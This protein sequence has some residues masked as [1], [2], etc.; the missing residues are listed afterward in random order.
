MSSYNDFFT[1][2]ASVAGALTGLLFVALSLAPERLRHVSGHLEHQA[3]AGTAFTALIDALFLSLAGLIPPGGTS[4]SLLIL[5]LLG[6]SSS[7]GL[8]WR[9]W[10]ARKEEKLSARWPF[11]LGVIIVAYGAQCVLSFTRSSTQGSDSVSATIVLIM[12]AIGIAR[13]WEL[14]GLSGGGV[15]D[16]LVQRMQAPQEPPSQ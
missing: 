14:L 1:A 5:G 7:I 9:L 11:L 6:L 3:I 10:H 8:A 16:L 4:G 15:L 2:S 12:F 13:S